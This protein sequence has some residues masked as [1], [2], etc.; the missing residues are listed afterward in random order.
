MQAKLQALIGHKTVETLV[1]ILPTLTGERGKALKLFLN[2]NKIRPFSS[3]KL[4]V[5][6]PTGLSD[7]S[8]LFS[9]FVF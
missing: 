8:L 1:E 6:L 5:Y 2:K 7:L 3:F 4:S 9:D